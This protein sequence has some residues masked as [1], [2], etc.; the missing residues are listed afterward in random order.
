MI[1]NL[2]WFVAGIL[3]CGLAALICL[4]V[5]A[6]PPPAGQTKTA[7]PEAL[8]AYG[9]LDVE[10]LTI[11]S[12]QLDRF[13]DLFDG[14]GPSDLADFLKK[15]GGKVAASASAGIRTG[16]DATVFQIKEGQFT[17]VLQMMPPDQIIISGHYVGTI[18]S[19]FN[20]LLQ[21]GHY[22]L[23]TM[24]DQPSGKGTESSFNAIVARVQGIHW[25]KV[26]APG[27][28]RAVS[29]SSSWGAFTFP[30]FFRASD[31]TVYE[32]RGDNIEGFAVK[33]G[34]PN[35]TIQNNKLV[36]NATGHVGRDDDTGWFSLPVSVSGNFQIDFDAYP[37]ANDAASWLTLF[38]DATDRGV[39]V[40]NATDTSCGT[41]SLTINSVSN[42]TQYDQFFIHPTTLA[43]VEAH[44]FANQTWTHITITREGNTLTDKVGGQIVTADLS[45]INFPTTVRIGLGY[46]ATK[47]VGG[48]GQFSYQNIRVIQKPKEASR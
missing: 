34:A 46:Y 7:A 36:G 19:S 37:D 20:S 40:M 22:Q 31:W 15:S 9:R 11:P 48:N 39:V 4:I 23:L 21:P 32:N 47:N 6:L 42:L 18:S 27:V 28:A 2:I 30:W 26:E 1:S 8:V 25:T 16:G 43:S 44:G 14:A 41:H 10:F 38:D 24:L 3:L 45:N 35:F 13:K 12:E 29:S 33:L 17:V 5:M